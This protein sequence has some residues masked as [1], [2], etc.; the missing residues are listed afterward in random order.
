[1][2]GRRQ[3]TTTRLQQVVEAQKNRPKPVL[4]SNRRGS[5]RERTFAQCSITTDYGYTVSGIVIDISDTGAR[6]RFRHHYRLAQHVTLKASRLGLK[7][8][9]EVV[10]QFGSDVGLRFV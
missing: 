9:C 1:M 5:A 7:Q 8:R 4:R 3:K 6:I 2:F 10:W